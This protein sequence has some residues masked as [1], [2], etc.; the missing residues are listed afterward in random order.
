[1]IFSFFEGGR[2]YIAFF[3]A[4][5][6]DNNN[7]NSSSRSSNSL[8]VDHISAV[9]WTPFDEK[10]ANRGF[11]VIKFD[12]RYMGLTQRFDNIIAPGGGE[13]SFAYTINDMADDA[14]AVLNHYG[15]SKAHVIGASIGGLITSHKWLVQD[16]QNVALL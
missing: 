6:D 8:T 7:N 16:T 14:V 13:P 11:H 4:D 3:A 5:D 10:I 2:Y 1:M 9:A 15:I 12:N